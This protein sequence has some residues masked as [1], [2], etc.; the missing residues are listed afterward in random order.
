MAITPTRCRLSASRKRW[1]TGARHAAVRG[2]QHNPLQGD[3]GYRRILELTIE[4]DGQPFPL[5]GIGHVGL[6]KL[7]REWN[8]LAVATT[9]L[10]QAIALGRAG[11]V[12]GIVLDGMITLALVRQAQ[13]D[14]AGAHAMIREG[15]QIAQAWGHPDTELR[16]AAFAARLDLAQGRIALAADWAGQAAA[17]VGDEPGERYE[18]E[19]LTIARAWIAQQKAADAARLLDRLLAAASSAGRMS[20]VIEILALRA[21]AAQ[22]LGNS[23]DARASIT[24]ALALGEPEGY[25]RVFVDEG[26]PMATLLAQI[27]R[28]TSAVA[29]Y[30]AK[31]LPDFGLESQIQNPKSKIQNLIEP[32]TDRELDVLRLLAAG[33]SNR[34]IARALVVAV[35]TVKKHLNTIFGK[36]GVTSRTQAIIAARKHHLV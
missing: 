11:G 26:E 12:E 32:L 7:H 34:E 14:S 6:G 3:Q 35:G 17:V 15:V 30:A 22:A 23:A 20:R 1:I 18:I 5:A 2:R 9:H 27:A 10:E 24:Q 13:G 25:V 28:G 16:V 31:L 29:G 36:L 8:D 21:L 33:H 19:Q 4:A